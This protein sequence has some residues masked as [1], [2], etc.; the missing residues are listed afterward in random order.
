M[1]HKS[2]LDPYPHQFPHDRKGFVPHPTDHW[3]EMQFEH[4]DMDPH[5]EG[6]SAEEQ[7]RRIEYLNTEWWPQ[8][9]DRVADERQR[10]EEEHG[11]SFITHWHTLMKQPPD[12]THGF[13][14]GTE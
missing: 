4:A 9:L 3:S 1:F 2:Q 7:A 6:I 12:N 13:G 8:V 14:L 11:E 10:L 5:E